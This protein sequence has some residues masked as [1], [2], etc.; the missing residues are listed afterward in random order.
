MP[1]PPHRLPRHLLS[2]LSTQYSVLRTIFSLSP[3]SLVLRPFFFFIT[4]FL[5]LSV[6]PALAHGYLLR[7]IP[8]DHAL[9]ER[10]PA[11]LQ[12]W[13]SEPLEP[14]FSAL[15]LRDQA[16]N[17]LASG[18]LSPGNQSLLTVRLPRG[19]PDGAYIVDMRLA[20][21]SDGHVVAQSRVFFVVEAVGGVSGQAASAQA[22]LLEALWRTLTLSSTL[23]L[24]GVVSLFA[25]LRNGWRDLP[26]CAA[27]TDAQR[28]DVVNYL[29]ALK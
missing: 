1:Y 19:L 13:F 3:Q 11:R 14:D 9:L 22:N 6:R 27:I 7:S 17:T 23:L 5:L 24:F 10:A 25:A 8:E 15:T 20:F 28:W 21:A 18:G 26:A 2:F 29:R 12:Y 16:G 4:L